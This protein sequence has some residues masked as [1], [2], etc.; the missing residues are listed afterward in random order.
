MRYSGSRSRVMVGGPRTLVPL[1]PPVPRRPGV[2]TPGGR[3]RG[4]RPG[5]VFLVPLLM[6]G[7]TDIPLRL[8]PRPGVDPPPDPQVQLG[9]PDGRPPQPLVGLLPPPAG[10]A[11]P[12]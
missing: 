1:P 6:V 3:P 8:P 5:Q 4:D 9:R 10:P 11:E 12:G 2:R 7:Q